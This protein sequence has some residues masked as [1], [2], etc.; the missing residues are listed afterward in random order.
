V[1]I[2]HLLISGHYSP[3]FCTRREKCDQRPAYVELRGAEQ[4]WGREDGQVG[5]DLIR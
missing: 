2:E 3:K 4:L 1:A 5:R